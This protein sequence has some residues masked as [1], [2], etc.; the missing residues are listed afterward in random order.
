MM[1]ASAAFLVAYAT[2]ILHPGAEPWV[3]RACRAVQVVVWAMFAVD[4]TVRVVLA[5]RRG[6]Y[7]MTHWLDLLAVA[8]PV[9]RP[10][11]VLRSLLMRSILGGHGARFFGGR[12]AA[13]VA[14]SAALVCLI[15]A[16]AV[17]DVERDA[18]GANIVTVPDALWWSMATVSTVGYGDRY[19]VTG[20]GRIV[21][22]AL[23]IT[24]IALLGVVTATIASWFVDRLETSRDAEEQA[25]TGASLD[26]LLAEIREL[27]T[28]VA[29][30]AEGVR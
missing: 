4:L 3:H 15:A 21:A 29:R 2:P 24:G 1:V 25:E 14:A 18:P 22:T 12:I 26:E 17:L 7:L 11:A 10:V 16:L 9:L 5:R 20:T 8:M 13:A 28:E 30:L 6:R 27:R 23:M 19:P